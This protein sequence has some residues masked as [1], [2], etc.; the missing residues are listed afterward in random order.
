MG[1]NEKSYVSAFYLTNVFFTI[2]YLEDFTRKMLIDKKMI[3]T[4]LLRQ[5]FI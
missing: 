5:L 4:L 1:M 3:E 2:Q